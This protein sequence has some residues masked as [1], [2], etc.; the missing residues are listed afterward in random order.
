MIAEID[1]GWADP[2]WA[3]GCVMN[4]IT[5]TYE[6][7]NEMCDMGIFKPQ[8]LCS[9]CGSVGMLI[10]KRGVGAPWT[11]CSCNSLVFYQCELMFR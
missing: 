9:L 4:A 3:E 5:E 6:L 2:A 8:D 11:K 1:Q 7:C 10:V